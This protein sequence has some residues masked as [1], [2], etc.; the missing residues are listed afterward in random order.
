MFNFLPVPPNNKLQNTTL[1][2]N[3]VKIGCRE[4]MQCLDQMLALFA[5]N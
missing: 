4:G 1:P 3:L 2:E 5:K